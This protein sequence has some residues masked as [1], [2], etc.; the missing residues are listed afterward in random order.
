[1][2]GP[3][4][5]CSLCGFEEEVGPNAGHTVV[6]GAH[7]TRAVSQGPQAGGQAGGRGWQAQSRT[8]AFQG[9]CVVLGVIQLQP[10]QPQGTSRCRGGR[11]VHTHLK[12]SQGL[13]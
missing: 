5:L 9:L 8:L 6:V 4:S 10:L 7:G 2:D 12:E 11:D 3:V 1:M 13:F